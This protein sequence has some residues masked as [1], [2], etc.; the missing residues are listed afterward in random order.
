MNCSSSP[1]L[2]S[3]NSLFPRPHTGTVKQGVIALEITGQVKFKVSLCYQISQG[4]LN[5]E[6]SNFSFSCV[7][8]ERMRSV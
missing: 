2:K 8:H 1:R 5:R 4:H 7:A 3:I 6:R